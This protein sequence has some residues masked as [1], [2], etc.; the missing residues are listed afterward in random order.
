M[1]EPLRE[2][3]NERVELVVY[4]KNNK[5]VNRLKHHGFLQYVSRKMNY[6]IMFIDR[7][8]KDEI[9]EKISHE[10]FVKRVEESPKGSMELTYDGL[11]DEMQK[12]I[13]RQKESNPEKFEFV[14]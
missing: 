14:R 8:D 12:E 3:F 9:I 2:D 4:L 13:N 10:H 6:A 1:K 11:L 5:Y 7:T